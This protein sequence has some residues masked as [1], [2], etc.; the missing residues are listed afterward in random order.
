MLARVLEIQGRSD[1]AIP[2]LK[3]TVGFMLRI[4]DKET[5]AKLQKYLELIESKKSMQKK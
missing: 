3:E 4:G 5:A 2:G 1:E